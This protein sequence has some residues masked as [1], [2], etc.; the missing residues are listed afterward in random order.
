MVDGWG[1]EEEEEETLE[2]Y[3]LHD[4]NSSISDITME[5]I[6]AQEEESSQNQ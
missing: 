2:Y 6:I 3:S 5:F 1:L 4:K